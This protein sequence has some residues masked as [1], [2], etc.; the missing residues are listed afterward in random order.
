M[1]RLTLPFIVPDQVNKTTITVTLGI[2]E[3]EKKGQ[4][5]ENKPDL[6]IENIKSFTNSLL[7]VLPIDFTCT[8][9]A[10][11]DSQ[12]VSQYDQYNKLLYDI[13]KRLKDYL[14]NIDSVI[15]IKGIQCIV[16]D[17]F[18]ISRQ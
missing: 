9:H 10:E 14:N 13:Q 8:D 11:K 2:S 6:S 12:K 15:S 18:T 17:Q 5:T 16:S 7:P 1:Y 3:T 4:V